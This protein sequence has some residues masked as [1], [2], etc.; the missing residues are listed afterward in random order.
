MALDFGKLNFSTSFNPTAA[1]PLD[2]RCY[3]ESLVAAENAAANAMPAGDSTTVYYYGMTLCVVE[4]SLATLYIIQPDKTLKEVGSVSNG[5]GL[6]IEV[7]EGKI[8]IKGFGNKYF[9]YIPAIQNEETGEI[10]T[11]STY[12]ETEGFIAGLEP[13]VVLNEEG[14]YEIA[15]YEPST[16]TLE[17]INS[18]VDSV[19]ATVE[20]IEDILNGND[21]QLGIIDKVNNLQEE[22]SEKAN[23]DNVYTKEEVYAK[24]EVYNKEEVYTK[25]EIYTKEETN[26]I[27]AA[28]VA[29][30]S[31]LKREIVDILPAEDIDENTI[32]MVPKPSAEGASVQDTDTY[33]E[34][35]YSNGKWEL[36][37]STQVDLTDYAKVEDI[38]DITEAL[39]KKVDAVEG[40]GLST[41]DFTDELLNKLNS[42][43]GDLESIGIEGIKINGID[44]AIEDGKVNIPLATVNNAG[45]VISSEEIG[46][47]KVETDGSMSVNGFDISNMVQET[48][49]I[50][51]FNGGSASE[52][53]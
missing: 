30:I 38:A 6:S 42:I 11:P 48:G 49:E 16:E 7:K 34:Y 43:N 9:K 4:S 12:E 36:I 31:S 25:E 5:D 53:V 1:F 32:Y 41:N 40:K 8:Q 20:T 14:K 46:K 28:A 19:V 21:E 24:E 22:V 39:D 15:W 51:I 17:G 37:G 3:F 13:R 2:A 26:T 33:N 18:K 23:A 35:M 27:I 44:L 50:I 52:G 47:V 45:V 29:N 10:V